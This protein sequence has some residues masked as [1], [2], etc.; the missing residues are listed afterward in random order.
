[1]RVCVRVC[2]REGGLVGKGDGGAY[3]YE[4]VGIK[5]FKML[6]FY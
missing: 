2:M 6:L 1:M 5:L 4:K 3:V